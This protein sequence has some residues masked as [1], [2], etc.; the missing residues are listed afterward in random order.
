MADEE[1]FLEESYNDDMT[2][3]ARD[4][5]GSQQTTFREFNVPPF[6]SVCE[7]TGPHSFGSWK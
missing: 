7:T 6:T 3:V 4:V 5:T 2:E 1:Q